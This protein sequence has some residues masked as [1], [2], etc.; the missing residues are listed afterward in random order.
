MSGTLFVVATPDRQPR[1]PDVP[2][3]AD[4]ARGRPHRRRG[5]APDGQAA[6]A[7]RD[8]EAARQPARAQRDAGDAPPDRAARGRARRSRWSPMPAHRASPTRAPGWCVPPGT[9]ASRGADPRAE[10]RRD[11]AVRVGLLRRTSSSSSASRLRLAPLE[12]RWFDALATET[13]D[14]RFL[15]GTSSDR[16]DADGTAMIM[17][18]RPIICLSRDDQDQRTIGRY[19]QITGDIDT[20]KLIGEFVV[21]VDRTGR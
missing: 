10:R 7:L 3:A 16:A 5:H 4:A 2:G 8:P 9:P 17:V 14:R 11:A 15:R 13:R 1:G 21:V 20:L 18:K 19:T 12:T 6:R